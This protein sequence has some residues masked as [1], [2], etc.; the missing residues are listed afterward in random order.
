MFD[1]LKNYSQSNY[2]PGRVAVN[3]SACT[4]CKQCT[5][6][7]P[8][9]ALEMTAKRRS[10]MKAGADCISCGACEAVCSSGA[11]RMKAFYHVPAGA[12]ETS[13]R[14]QKTGKDAFPRNFGATDG[15]AG[16]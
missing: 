3:E 15:K 13:G 9:G 14:R 2:V 8:A 16:R 4:G 10:R 6:V 1:W 5:I 11:I 7:C 12:Y